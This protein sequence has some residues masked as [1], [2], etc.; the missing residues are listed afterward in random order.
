MQT[1]LITG[2]SSGIG[3]EMSRHFARGAYRILWVSKP[4]Q[5]LADAKVR[6]ESEIEGVDIHTLAQDL[7][8][9]DAAQTVFDWAASIGVVDVLI[10][11]AGFG[12]FG[13]TQEIPME[14]D[15]TMMNLHIIGTYQ[16]TRIFLENMLTRN[17][18]TIINIS[19]ITG[20][21][22]IV[23][24]NVY[25]S[26]KAFIHHFSRGLQEE[27][28]LQKTKVK[29]VTVCPAAIG[30][31]PFKTSADMEDVKTFTKGLVTT[32]AEEVARDVWRGF[33]R[34]KTYIITGRKARW[35]YKTQWLLP[36]WLE[37]YLVRRESE[38]G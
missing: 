38:R 1:V 2:G 22:P 6:L 23:R 4:P 12:S 31:T 33:N 29:V 16:M 18:G 5:E 17:A 37:Q 21:Q 24:M 36:Y 11:N 10:N 27:L 3:Y 32:T 25:A 20:L 7:S 26:T 34:G 13:F 8:E 9:K 30:N 14:K 35:I 28:K 15:V 19:S